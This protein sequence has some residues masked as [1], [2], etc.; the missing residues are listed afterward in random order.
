MELRDPAMGAARAVGQAWVGSLHSRLGADV[1]KEAQRGSM[2]EPGSC[3]Q[4]VT[5]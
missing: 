3:S 1:E 4:Q 2:T 5:P